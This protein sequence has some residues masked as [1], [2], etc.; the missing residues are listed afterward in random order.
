MNTTHLV[1]VRHI[2]TTWNA[3]RRK[4]GQ[5]DSPPTAVGKAQARA[6]ANRFAAEE[7]KYAALY[8]S[9]LGRARFTAEE[10]GKLTNHEVLFENGLRERHFGIF[11]GLTDAECSEKFPHEFA[12]WQADLADYPIPDGESWRAFHARVV[13]C[14]ESLAARHAGARIVVVTHGG[15]L[16]TLFRHVFEIPLGKPRHAKLWNAG[17][18]IFTRAAANVWQLNSWGDRHHLRNTG[19]IDDS[20]VP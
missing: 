17:I 5:L 15:V 2:E 19:A 8:S 4:Q 14:F 13:E 16:D 9:D 10:I 12:A 11:G 6:L 3:D 18:N 1:V 20:T 7:E